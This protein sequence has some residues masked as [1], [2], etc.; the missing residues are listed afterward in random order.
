MDQF[1]IIIYLVLV[2]SLFIALH[3]P[4]SAYKYWPP[5]MLKDHYYPLLLMTTNVS[6]TQNIQ[7]NGNNNSFFGH[8]KFA[9]GNFIV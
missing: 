3:P 6:F 1:L 5:R 9:V 4:S 2:V 8:V 7:K